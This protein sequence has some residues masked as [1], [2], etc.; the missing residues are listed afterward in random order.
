MK[1]NFFEFF[2]LTTFLLVEGKFITVRRVSKIEKKNCQYNKQCPSGFSCYEGSCTL[3]HL[4]PA[5]RDGSE[6]YKEGEKFKRN[7]D[8]CQCLSSKIV[9]KRHTCQKINL[10]P[11]KQCKNPKPS[12]EKNLYN[13]PFINWKCDKNKKTR[14]ASL[15]A[16]LDCNKKF[17]CKAN[18]TKTKSRSSKFKVCATIFSS[19]K[20]SKKCKKIVSLKKK[21]VLRNEGCKYS[22]KID[23][24]LCT[25]QT[26][27]KSSLGEVRQVKFLCQNGKTIE[28]K[29][30]LFCLLK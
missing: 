27:Y 16:K 22:T 1:I 28:K 3:K 2:Y 19:K 18:R 12:F 11:P 30:Q 23:R 9:C 26:S 6:L 20:K 13:C 17:N 7:F 15:E 8:E 24:K 29:V 10:K 14:P 25:K 21:L 5:C 4:L